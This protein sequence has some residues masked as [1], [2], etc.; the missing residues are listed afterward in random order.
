MLKETVDLITV[1][2][3]QLPAFLTLHVIAFTAAAVIGADVFIASRRFLIDNIFIYQ[4]ISGQAVQTS[5]YGSLSDIY[6]LGTEVI[7]YFL[8][9]KVGSG[10]VLKEI[11]YLT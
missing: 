5:V 3:D 8:T 11:Q 2:M 4:A 6:A 7:G 10:I 9:C 1:Q